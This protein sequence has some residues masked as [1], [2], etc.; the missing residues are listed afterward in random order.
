MKL[1]KSL[2]MTAVAA[3]A[4]TSC[5]DKGYWEPYELEDT[6]YSFAQSKQTFNLTADES[7]TSVTVAV[8]R[9]NAEGAVTLP[10]AVTVSDPTVLT[11]DSVVTFAD[12]EDVA[13]LLVAVN[14]ENIVM[15]TAYTV[16]YA[17]AVDSVNFTEANYSISGNSS[18]VISIKK[19][20]TWVSLGVGVYTSQLFGE[21]WE[22]PVLYA[23]EQP[24]RYRLPDCIY[25]GYPFEFVL[26][27][28]GQEL[29]EW[30]P[31][32][33]GYKDSTYGMMYYYPQ[34]MQRDGKNLYFDMLGLVV[35]NG[36]LATLYSGFV[37]TLVL[38]S[39]E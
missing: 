25:T 9:S 34:A 17:F 35:Y 8:Y 23:K 6:Q 32:A 22:Q 36:G 27:E 37:E 28:D 30:E 10:L 19:D 16:N 29:V 7:I 1:Y 26:S 24:N 31:Q 4:F 3:V 12:G 11:V 13:E 18:H 20:Y 14:E 21:S 33:T 2:L 15:G 38:P 5:S 39:A